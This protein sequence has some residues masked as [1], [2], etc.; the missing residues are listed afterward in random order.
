MKEKLIDILKRTKFSAHIIRAI[1]GAYVA[2]TCGKVAVAYFTSDEV[3]I[4]LFIG[5]VIIA[6]LGAAIALLGL[7]AI[8]KGYSIEYNGRAPWEDPPEEETNESEQLPEQSENSSK[9]EE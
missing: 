5:A 6:L 8:V 1:V 7:W 4:A 2:Y 9:Q 3:T